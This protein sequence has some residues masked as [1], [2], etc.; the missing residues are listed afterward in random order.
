MAAA[1]PLTPA[2]SE[3]IF[4]Y[5]SGHD[6]IEM[7]ED[8]RDLYVQGLLDQ[9]FLTLAIYDD[10]ETLIWLEDC[11]AGKNS[12]QVA[13]QFTD[14]V[15]AHRHELDLPA[16]QLFVAAIMETCVQST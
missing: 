10:Y 7:S 1:V 5:N 14:W 8:Y 11:T 15:D 3:T 16:P 12:D 6:Y 13:E 9:W 4:S 2:S